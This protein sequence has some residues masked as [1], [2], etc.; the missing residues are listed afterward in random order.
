MINTVPVTL[1]NAKNIA[2][3]YIRCGIIPHFIAPPGVGKTSIVKEIAKLLEADLYHIRLNNTP[4]EEAIGLQFIEEGQNGEKYTVRLPSKWVPKADGSDGPRIIFFDEF[5]QAPD[6]Y[7]KGIMSALLE[8]YIGENTLPDNCYFIA[9]SNS[10]EDG[11]NVYEM[12]RATADRFGIIKIRADIGSWANNYANQKKLNISV[13]AFL[14]N[15][16]DLFETSEILNHSGDLIGGSPRTWESVSKYLDQGK[17]DG[18]PPDDLKTG[19]MGLIGQTCAESFWSVQGEILNLP[20]LDELLDMKPEEQKKNSPQTMDALWMYGQ[21][22]IWKSTNE[23]NIKR[24]F[25]LLDHFKTPETI[26][27]YETRTH[28][29][30]SI[31]ERARRLY[32]MDCG[33]FPEITEKIIQWENESNPYIEIL[34]AA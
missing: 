25:D 15:R 24:I 9:A 22:M 19:L 17:Q 8:R 20:T 5:S 27:Y 29:V 10:V 23:N 4:P 33:V 28:I 6:D 18:L 11:T 32:N 3:S 30:E 1:E 16:E 7:R 26:P 2:L 12:D 31:L 21:S 14:R 34:K 13:V